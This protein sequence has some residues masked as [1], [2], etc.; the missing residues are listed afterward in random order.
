MKAN[1]GMTDQAARIVI[2]V[3]LLSL[4]VIL[5]G[6]ARWLGLIGLVPIATAL[7]SYCPLYSL[8][9]VASGSNEA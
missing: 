2:G 5:E 9:G 8:L 4:A 1:V 3:A 7:L 6:G